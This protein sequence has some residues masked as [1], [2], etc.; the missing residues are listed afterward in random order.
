MKTDPPVRADGRCALRGCGKPR[1]I[2]RSY[3]R[4][5][6]PAVYEREPFCSSTCCRLYYGI[7][8]QTVLGG[9][10]AERRGRHERV[11]A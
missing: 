8:L 6:D 10:P 5:I 9:D 3:P 4:G 11:A 7:P 2:V 1:K